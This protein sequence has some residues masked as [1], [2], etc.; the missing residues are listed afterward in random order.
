M[1]LAV[2]LIPSLFV[3]LATLASAASAFAQQ[4]LP[5]EVDAA[6]ARA[7]VPREAVTM[8]VADAD[9]TCARRAWP[10]ARRCR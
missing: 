6:L 7:R 3:S 2:R 10:G 1:P 9:G 5:P 8:L 4:A